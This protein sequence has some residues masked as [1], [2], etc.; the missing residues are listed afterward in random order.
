MT[1]A[2]HH[3]TAIEASLLQRLAAAQTPLRTRPSSLRRG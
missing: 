3:F 2:G 1:M